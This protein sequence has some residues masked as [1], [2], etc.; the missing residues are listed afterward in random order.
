MLKTKTTAREMKDAFNGSINRVDIK[1]KVHE[2]EYRSIDTTQTEIQKNKEYA[3]RG[4][5]R[6][7]HPRTVR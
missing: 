2:L 3:G 7:E 5:G 1:R 6:T 4:A